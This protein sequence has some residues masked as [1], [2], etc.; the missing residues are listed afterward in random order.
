MKSAKSPND[1]L[2]S[3]YSTFSVS[4]GVFHK[5]FVIYWDIILASWALVNPPHKL[6]FSTSL[7]V[8]IPF[9]NAHS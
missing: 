4:A 9:C 3:A 1:S 7:I 8:V 6:A 2:T 5:T